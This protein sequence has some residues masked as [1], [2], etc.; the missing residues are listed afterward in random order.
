MS[1]DRLAAALEKAFTGQPSPKL[2]SYTFPS[3]GY[4]DIEVAYSETPFLHT[5]LFPEYL[6]VHRVWLNARIYFTPN[7]EF[8]EEQ[9]RLGKSKYL[10]TD[11]NMFA[12]A[13]TKP[14]L[15]AAKAVA[16]YSLVVEDVGQGRIRGVHFTLHDG[17]AVPT[18]L[19]DSSGDK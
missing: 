19:Y 5:E 15:D 17:P 12:I 18:W 4:R 11:D 6:R 2:T 8:I 13:Q 10:F 7:E 16:D 14:T 1:T 9:R 3:T